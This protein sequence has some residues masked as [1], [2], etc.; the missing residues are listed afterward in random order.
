MRL[1]S[2][3]SVNHDFILLSIGYWGLETGDWGLGIGELGAPSGDKGQWGLGIGIS[4]LLLR[5]L[6]LNPCT[7]AINRVSTLKFF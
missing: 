1:C 4:P 3:F 6:T 2:K 7:D 5:L